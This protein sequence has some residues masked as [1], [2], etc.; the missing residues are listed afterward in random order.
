MNGL[1]HRE[2]AARVFRF[3]A[4]VLVC[5]CAGMSCFVRAFP[6]SGSRS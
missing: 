1:M 2:K 3:C 6:D 5:V 4:S